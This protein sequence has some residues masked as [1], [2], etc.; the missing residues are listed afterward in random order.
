M[1]CDT[2][3]YVGRPSYANP[4]SRCDMKEYS[5]LCMYEKK[6]RVTNG[7]R[8]R[9]MSNE[10]LAKWIAEVIISHAEGSI[11]KF[12]ISSNVTR[13]SKESIEEGCLEWLQR[14]I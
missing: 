1:I 2:C 14:P 6:V 9:S 10:K 13:E 12:G 4:C 11:R 8:I 5:S 7:D 3:E